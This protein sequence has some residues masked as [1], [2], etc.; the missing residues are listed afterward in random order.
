MSQKTLALAFSCFCLALT[1]A[2]PVCAQRGRGRGP[3]P[4]IRE[5]YGNYFVGTALPTGGED[6]ESRVSLLPLLQQAAKDE[7]LSVVYLYDSKQD[8][9]K[10]EQFEQ[11]LFN[12]P[13]LQ[14]ALRSFLCARIDL[15]QHALTREELEKK[16]PLFLVVNQKGKVAAEVSMSG[17]K[18]NASAL[19]SGLT[20]ASRGYAKL[21]LKSFTKQYQKFL[22][23]FTLLEGRKRGLEQRRQRL[24]ADGG[25]AA[26]LKKL[27]AE[28]HKLASEEE[29]L[30]TAEKTLLE[31]AR[32]PE[33]PNEAQLVGERRWG[34]R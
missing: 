25:N 24:A 4:A 14:V 28:E 2:S 1:V 31:R 13:Q 19:L 16:T 11:A 7:R 20:R 33:R 29:D 32:I 15:T 30:L 17:Y 8:E 3:S 22:R 5:R 34:R 23:D 6:L 18:A 9:K 27:E 12:V 21:N 26:K 10:H